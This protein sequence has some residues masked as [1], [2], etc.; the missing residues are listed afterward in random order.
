MILQTKR[1]NGMTT[2]MTTLSGNRFLQGFSTAFSVGSPNAL[3]RGAVV[4][5][6]TALHITINLSLTLSVRT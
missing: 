1:R 3:A 4:Q 6:E 2:A 5:E